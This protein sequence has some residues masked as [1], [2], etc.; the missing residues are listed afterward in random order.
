MPNLIL[1]DL[2][3]I[4]QHLLPLTYTRPV[5]D[6]L[7]GILTLR[8]RWEFLLK[9][10]AS[11][12]SEPYLQNKFKLHIHDHNLVIASH[13]KPSPQLIQYI[14][15][16]TQPDTLYFSQNKWVWGNIS[17]K[18]WQAFVRQDYSPFHL[19]TMDIPIDS[20]SACWQIF[21][22]CDADLRFDFSLIT[23]GRFS[24]P[25]ADD[26]QLIGP[27]N[28]LFIEDGALVH[29]TI[30]N[31]TSGPI[32]IGK[33][34]EIMEGALIRGPFALG[35][36][37][38]VKMGAKIYG[39]T[40]LGP[41]TKAGG[42]LNN[43][44]VFGFSSKAHDGFLGNAVIGEWC[45]LGAD[46]NNSNLKNNYA[47]VKLWNY[48]SQKF[49]NTGLQFCGLI[50]ADHSKSGINTMFN[51]GTVVGVSANIFGAGFPRNFIPSFAWG[52]P[53]GL[54]I[55]QLETA[56]QTASLVYQRRG[57]SFDETEIAILREVFIRSASY[58]QNLK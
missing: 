37:S 48:A 40:S 14:Q 43:V 35:M 26:N 38:Q 10:S 42:E 45:N 6:L 8:Q 55:Y 9:Q 23:Q 2:P 7:T 24:Q 33:N 41:H 18:N 3:D 50:M 19:R 20:I 21:Q 56:L 17:Q 46:T 58:R 30:L 11:S 22:S 12:Y 5:A 51:T 25:L 34:A 15:T 44:V 16:E 1:F 47:P 27:A 29:G 39:A 52:G 31:T 4:R 53:Q 49:E 54:S 13:I 36:H 28:Q 57:V 32:Y